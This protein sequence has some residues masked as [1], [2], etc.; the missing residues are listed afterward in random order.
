MPINRKLHEI[1]IA[2]GYSYKAK[3]YMDIYQKDDKLIFVYMNDYMLMMINNRGA[4]SQEFA[5]EIK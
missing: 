1:L 4:T 3:T 5:E 2:K